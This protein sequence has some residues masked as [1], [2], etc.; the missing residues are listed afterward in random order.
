M[1]PPQAT[2]PPP[3]AGPS[4]SPVWK[5]TLAMLVPRAYW[6]RCSTRA[7]SA[8]YTGVRKQRTMPVRHTAAYIGHTPW[9][10]SQPRVT[11]SRISGVSSRPKDAA[12]P[13]LRRGRWSTR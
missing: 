11:H 10:G 12:M 13:S 9:A 1:V 8:L 4:T 7:N 6:R 5:N 2:R 3:S